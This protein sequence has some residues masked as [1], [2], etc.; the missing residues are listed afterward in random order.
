V[1]DYELVAICG[2]FA[3]GIDKVGG[4][5][6]GK[7][8]GQEHWEVSTRRKGGEWE[9]PELMYVGR[10]VTHQEAAEIARESIELREAL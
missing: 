1:S 4:G 9:G 2:D 7:R 3:L 5:T 6:V 8:Y 10:P